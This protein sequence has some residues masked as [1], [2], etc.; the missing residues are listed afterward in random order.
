LISFIDN[1]I[2]IKLSAFGL[3]DDLRELIAFRNSEPFVLGTARMVIDKPSKGLSPY[4]R[5][6]ARSFISAASPIPQIILRSDIQQLLLNEGVQPKDALLLHACAVSPQAD[7]ITGD[8]RLIRAVA[9]DPRALLVRSQLVGRFVCLEQ[10]ILNIVGQIGFESV[11]QQF[12]AA[13][14]GNVYEHDTVVQRALEC[15]DAKIAIAQLSTTI[16]K[17]RRDVGDLLV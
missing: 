7:L 4:A 10:V 5:T 8:K 14:T 3:I 12:G 1:D 16:R 11:S 17:L 6:R 2:I 9:S 13:M 15:Q